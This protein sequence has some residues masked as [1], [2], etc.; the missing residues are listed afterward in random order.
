MSLITPSIVAQKI[1]RN[2]SETFRSILADTDD[3][4]IDSKVMPF[5]ALAGIGSGLDRASLRSMGNTIDSL[6]LLIAVAAFAGIIGAFIGLFLYSWI[7]SYTNKWLGGTGSFDRIKTA[8]AWAS[9]PFVFVALLWIP[10][11]IFFKMDNFSDTTPILDSSPTLLY[12]YLGILCVETI[13]VI[14]CC[15]IWLKG[16]GRACNFSAW[17]ALGTVII[18]AL[19]LFIPIAIITTLLF[20]TLR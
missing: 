12:T 15:V 3:P 2:P 14:Y 11:L 9:I 19:V 16:L 5:V 4:Y 8:L 7:F 13:I 10:N 20:V 17:K 6:P 18:S 1:W